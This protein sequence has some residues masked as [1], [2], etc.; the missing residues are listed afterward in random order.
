MMANNLENGDSD[1]PPQLSRILTIAFPYYCGSENP[2]HDQIAANVSKLSGHHSYQVLSANEK[3][4][5][6]P[7]HAFSTRKRSLI[8]SPTPIR[9]TI[10]L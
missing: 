8:S 2:Y 1:E 10:L 9:L 4:A 5:T 7:T 3:T 6:F